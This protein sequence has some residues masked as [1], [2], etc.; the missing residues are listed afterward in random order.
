MSFWLYVL[1]LTHFRI[2]LLVTDALLRGRV[3]VIANLLHCRVPNSEYTVLYST[4]G[5]GM[6]ERDQIVKKR[7]YKHCMQCTVIE[8]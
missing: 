8:Q 2:F 3:V 6:P 4:T 1:W 7:R 5:C